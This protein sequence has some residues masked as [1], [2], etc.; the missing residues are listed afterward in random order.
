MS[1]WSSG[2]IVRGTTFPANRGGCRARCARHRIRSL[3]ESIH[4]ATAGGCLIFHVSGAL[5]Q[6][7]RDLIHEGTTA[8]LSTAT[9]TRQ[10]RWEEA[11]P[12]RRKPQNARMLLV[13][14]P[15][16]HAV[17]TR[18]NIGTTALQDALRGTAQEPRQSQMSSNC[19]VA[20]TRPNCEATPPLP[21]VRISGS[22]FIDLGQTGGAMG[23]T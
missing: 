1:W 11:R 6:V 17:A 14:E 2:L 21:S 22:T 20:H 13:Q 18:L 5:G 15:H 12:H 8:G 16:V 9:P 4:M 19:R 7:N 10:Q 3:S 23:E